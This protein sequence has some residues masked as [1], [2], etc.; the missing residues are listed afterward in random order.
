MRISLG[1]KMHL[2]TFFSDKSFH[3][4]AQFRSLYAKSCSGLAMQWCS[5]SSNDEVYFVRQNMSVN[6][7]LVKL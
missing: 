3:N 6:K 7:K 5:L 2:F 4:I 1:H